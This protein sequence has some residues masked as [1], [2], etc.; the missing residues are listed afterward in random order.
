MRQNSGKRAANTRG[1]AA[2]GATKKT[3]KKNVRNKKFKN[4]RLFK[5]LRVALLFI[6]ILL[7]FNIMKDL[8]T[9]KPEKVSVVIGDEK[10]ALI[11]EIEIDKDNNILMS[12]DD[13]K[14]LYDSNIYYS[15]HTVI[16]TYNKHLAVLELDKTTMKVNDVVQEI[17]GTLKEKDG[18]VYLPFS[19]MEDVYDFAENYNKDTKVLS[20]DSKSEEKREAVVLKNVKLKESTKKFAKTLEK[21]KK[22]QYVTV[23]GTEGDFTKVRTKAG[24]IGYIKTKKLSK[25]E[26]LWENMDEEKIESVTV[27]NDYSIVDTKYEILQSA[28]K[29]AI[30]T[31]NL[32]QIVQTN[33]DKVDVQNVIDLK[34]TRFVTYKDWANGSGVTICPTVTLKCS[35]SKVCSSYENRSFIINTLYN[36]LIDNKLNMI[37]IDFTEIDD[38][39][40][41][42]RFV[43]EM[44]P[45]FKC[46]GMKVLVKYNS[47]FNKDRLNNIVDY[48]LD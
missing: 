29:D 22:T 6:I 28:P 48:V 36:E 2:A 31:P 15:N 21:V 11:H 10:I 18:T 14:K 40:G 42:Y 1:G 44:V 46:A 26:L 5:I 20:I 30:V 35:M 4:T 9:K 32:F 25:P 45:R 41:V 12:I 24:N 7:I 34:G 27:L 3:A 43:T 47:S 39:E 33:D 8:T 13:I 16:T 17:K 37:C 19:D 38:T 23:F